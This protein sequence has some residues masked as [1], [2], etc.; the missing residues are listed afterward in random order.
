[1]YIE[2]VPYCLI[3]AGSRARFVHGMPQ[4]TVY[5]IVSARPTKTSDVKRQL[6]CRYFCEISA[7]SESKFAKDVIWNN[8]TSIPLFEAKYVY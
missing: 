6:V 2:L 8:L 4:L 7:T 1:M 3:L 5:E